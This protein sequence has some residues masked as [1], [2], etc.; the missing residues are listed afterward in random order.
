ME[1]GDELVGLCRDRGIRYLAVSTTQMFKP[2]SGAAYSE[3]DRP[4]AR[5][6]AALRAASTEARLACLC[7][8]ALIVRAGPVFGPWDEDNFALRLLQA[9]ASGRRLKLPAEIASPSYLPDLVHTALDLLIDGESGLW[10][11]PNAGQAS[12]SDIAH[13][14]AER[15]GMAP[16]VRARGGDGAMRTSALTSER[17][18]VMPALTGALHRFVGECESN[19]RSNPELAGIAAE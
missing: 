3:N 7:P 17:G 5:D 19:W 8:E 6:P 18:M 14:L 13:I 11:L 10:H 15:A 9:L 16:P 12:W 1:A 4:N 2:R